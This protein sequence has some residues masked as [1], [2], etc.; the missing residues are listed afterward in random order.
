MKLWYAHNLQ[1]INS[2]IP[3]SDPKRYTG[4]THY[5]QGNNVRPD[6]NERFLE[7]KCFTLLFL[8]RLIVT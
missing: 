5:Y 4:G 6:E 8:M 1:S 2:G 3:H 7:C